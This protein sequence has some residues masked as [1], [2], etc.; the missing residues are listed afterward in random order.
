MGASVHIGCRRG[1]KYHCGLS[2]HGDIDIIPPGTPS[3]W[4]PREKDTAFIMRV[5]VS[6][7]S[8]VADEAGI[9]PA[10]VEIG[11]SLP[12]ARSADGAYRMGSEGGDG[13]GLSERTAVSG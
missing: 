12:D 2:V 7:L 1:G 11:E 8:L 6:F 5:P 4:E 13:G 10:R 9:D 3:R